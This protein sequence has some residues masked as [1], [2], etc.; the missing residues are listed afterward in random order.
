MAPRSCPGPPRCHDAAG[1]KQRVRGEEPGSP[2]RADGQVPHLPGRGRAAWGRELAVGF[3]AGVRG[4]HRRPTALVRQGLGLTGDIDDVVRD[5]DKLFRATARVQSLKALLVADDDADQLRAKMCA[6]LFGQRGHG[7]LELTRALLIENADGSSDKYSELAEQGLEGFHWNGVARI[8]GYRASEPSVD[9]FVLWM[10][11]RAIKKNGFA[12]DPPGALR[13]IQLDF[14]SLRNDRRSAA[15]L[16]TLARRVSRSLDYASSI[17]DVDLPA[18]AG[19]DLFEDVERKVV[20]TLARA[21]ADRTM[22]VREVSETIRARQSSIWI[23]GYRELY[24][25]PWRGVAAAGHARDR[26]VRDLFVRWGARQV[27]AGLVPDRPAIPAVPL[28]GPDDRVCGSAG[29]AAHG[30]GEALREQ[31]PL[32]AWQRVA[33]AGRRGR[34]LAIGDATTATALASPRRCWSSASLSCSRVPRD[35]C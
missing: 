1:S 13:N 6:V 17:E 4:V 31:V 19:N 18:L 16:A 35:R 12:S 32:R 24:A 5:H 10:F 22:S 7:M 9:D 2:R 26:E 34:A 28:R 30:G 8:Y 33:A 27:S 15:A 3:G 21:V 23:D 29:G 11:R 25:A 14:A 20:S